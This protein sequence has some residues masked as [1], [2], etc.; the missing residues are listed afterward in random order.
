MLSLRSIEEVEAWLK[1]REDEQAKDEVRI[2]IDRV[3][4]HY[5][6]Q[7]SEKTEKDPYDILQAYGAILEK[8]PVSPLQVADVQELPYP[9]EIIKEAVLSVLEITDDP[10]LQ[11]N[12]FEAYHLLAHWQPE[13]GPNRVGVANISRTNLDIEKDELSEECLEELKSFLGDVEE[14][15]KWESTVRTEQEKLLKDLERYEL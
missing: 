5:F 6:Y 8:M 13:V 4:K 15:K 12:L 1:Y 7:Q 3:V 11:R 10:Q 2:E 9:K 14:W